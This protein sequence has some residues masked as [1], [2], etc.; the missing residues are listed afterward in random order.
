MKS[1]SDIGTDYLQ[2]AKAQ[3]KAEAELEVVGGCG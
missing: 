2:Y 3:A 1:N